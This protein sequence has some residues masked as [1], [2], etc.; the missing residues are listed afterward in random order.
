[1]DFNSPIIGKYLKKMEKRI[2]FYK[3]IENMSNDKFE[4]IKELSLFED[5]VHLLTLAENS[6][7]QAYR[8]YLHIPSI[9]LKDID[10]VDCTLDY[11]FHEKHHFNIPLVK[12]DLGMMTLLDVDAI[13]LAIA[14]EYKMLWN[15]HQELFWGHHW[16]DLWIERLILRGNILR[17]L[18]GS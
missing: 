10:T 9:L 6:E 12:N 11:P 18:I 13:L 1:M 3:D 5:K 14:N 17:A 8:H 16:G 2:L 4:K 7:K 15:E